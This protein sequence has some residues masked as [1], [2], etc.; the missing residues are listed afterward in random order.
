LELGDELQAPA[1]EQ[2]IRTNANFQ[3]GQRA[4]LLLQPLEPVISCPS[5]ELLVLEPQPEPELEAL[6]VLEPDWALP[7]SAQE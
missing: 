2:L 1:V 5:L 4:R 7:G 6:A 3:P